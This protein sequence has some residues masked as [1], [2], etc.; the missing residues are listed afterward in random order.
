MKQNGMQLEGYNQEQ[1]LISCHQR[2]T[3]PK[4]ENI[5]N[6]AKMDSVMILE[7]RTYTRTVS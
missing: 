5:S 3:I 4:K 1:I 6:A 7:D 2:S